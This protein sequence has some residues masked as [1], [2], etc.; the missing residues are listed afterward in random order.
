MTWDY[1]DDQYKKQAAAD[2]VWKLERM[3]NYGLNGEKLNKKLLVKHF[4]E[5]KIPEERRS[6]LKLLL[7]GSWY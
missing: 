4:D 7:W 1:K 6:F 3:I 2:P 5:I